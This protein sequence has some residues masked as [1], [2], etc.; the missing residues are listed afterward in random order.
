MRSLKGC[1]NPH[2]RAH[3]KFAALKR[4]Y[5]VNFTFGGFQGKNERAIRTV[6]F[7]LEGGGF[8]AAVF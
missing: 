3:R 6:R 2:Q 1:G 7:Y 4:R 8:Y 5:I